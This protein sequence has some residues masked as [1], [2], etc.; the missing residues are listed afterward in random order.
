MAKKKAPAGGAVVCGIIA[1][2]LAA[3][4]LYLVVGGIAKQVGGLP[5]TTVLWWYFGGFIL[6]MLAKFCKIKAGVRS[7]S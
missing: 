3:I 2:I 1:A 5:W 6:F 4:G 7:L